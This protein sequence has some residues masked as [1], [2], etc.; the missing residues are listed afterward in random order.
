MNTNFDKTFTT[1][2]IWGTHVKFSSIIKPRNLTL[3]TRD[4]ILLPKTSSLVEDG[5][6]RCFLWNITYWVLSS[7]KVKRLH[8]SHA[9]IFFKTSLALY[10][11]KFKSWW[12]MN[13]LVSS[14]NRANLASREQYTKYCSCG[15]SQCTCINSTIQLHSQL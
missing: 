8:E 14:A 2:L 7:F 9:C 15:M 3:V 5:R 11:S 13:T 4:T 6:P 12:F 1:L 10:T